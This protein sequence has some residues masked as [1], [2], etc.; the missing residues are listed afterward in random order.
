[1]NPTTLS[2]N[3]QLLCPSTDVDAIRN[4]S[5]PSLHS[6]SVQTPLCVWTVT[7]YKRSLLLTLRT[8]VQPRT[9]QGWKSALSY[10]S[11][12]TST[13]HC[14]C[15]EKCRTKCRNWQRTKPL[16]WYRVIFWPR[17]CDIDQDFL[18]NMIGIDLKFH[19]ERFL[20]MSLK[21]VTAVWSSWRW[22][23]SY[24]CR[25]KYMEMERKMP[26]RK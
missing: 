8:P 4:H 7:T 23:P 11:G 14:H 12:S 10:R 18:L 19:F 6:P 16:H 24:M 15:G 1:M 5:H 26:V 17:S 13:L 9:L 22:Q 21:I 25:P 2:F 20:W 3:S